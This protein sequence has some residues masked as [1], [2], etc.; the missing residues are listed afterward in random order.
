MITNAYISDNI[1]EWMKTVIHGNFVELYIGTYKSFSQNQITIYIVHR[2]K[3]VYILW[4][5]ICTCYSRLKSFFYPQLLDNCYYTSLVRVLSIYYYI[6]KKYHVRYDT[7]HK[8]IGTV[9]III[10]PFWYFI[11]FYVESVS[12]LYYDDYV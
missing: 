12:W 1:V 6:K 9:R 7:Q 4:Y 8:I 11:I 10:T 3:R 2:Y 5:N